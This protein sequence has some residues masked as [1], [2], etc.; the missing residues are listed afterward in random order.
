MRAKDRLIVVKLRKT[1]DYPMYTKYTN[2]KECGSVA[3]AEKSI[4]TTL[5][6]APA[7]G[8][9]KHHYQSPVRL[10]HKTAG[11][12]IAGSAMRLTDESYG[13]LY[14]WQNA[15]HGQWFKTLAEAQ[16]NFSKLTK[17]REIV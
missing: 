3:D 7:T 12:E 4:R 10:V 2:I 16:R 1:G 5:S 8:E 15:G 11:Y 9:N 6:S 14:M 13:V 17:A